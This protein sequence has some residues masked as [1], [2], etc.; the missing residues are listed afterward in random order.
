[1][2]NMCRYCVNA[3]RTSEGKLVLLG[4][5]RQLDCERAKYE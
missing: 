2:D 4:K 1:M 3:V 5:T